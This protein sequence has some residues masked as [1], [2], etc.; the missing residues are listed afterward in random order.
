MRSLVLAIWLTGT[1]P[2]MA[3]Q[4]LPLYP[5]AI[6]NALAAPDRESVR[7]AKEAFPFLQGVSRPTLTPYLPMRRD[8]KRTAVVILPGGGY[9]GVSIE[10]EGHAVARAFNDMGVAAF[11]LKYRTPDPAQMKDPTLGPLQDVQQALS[12]VRSRAD[13]W[14]IDRERVGLLG[15]SAGGHLAATAATRFDKPVLA[16][17][18]GA[19]LRPDFLM[20]I[21]PVVTFEGVSA[22]AGSRQQLL[23]DTPDPATIREYS[24]ERHVT[25]DTPLTFIVHAAD[26]ASVPVDNSIRFFEAL[27]RYKVPVELIVYPAGGH[28]FGLNNATTA[29]RWVERGQQWLQSQGL[30]SQP[31]RHSSQVR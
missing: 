9:R 15:F 3:Q 11:V 23:G 4:A 20:L 6:P 19:N 12:T 13:E 2:A 5:G 25:A 31:V 16:E 29:D 17:W 10:K 26:D 14:N 27:Q 28:G 22:H 7:D 18:R 24:S 1:L 21:Y 30:L 8:A